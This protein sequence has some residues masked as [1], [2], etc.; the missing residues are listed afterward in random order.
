MLILG[1]TGSRGQPP[2]VLS[3]RS[4]IV[5]YFPINVAMESKEADMAEECGNYEIF[6][7]FYHI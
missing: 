4:H 7:N 5:T 1:G 6:G 2:G 3:H